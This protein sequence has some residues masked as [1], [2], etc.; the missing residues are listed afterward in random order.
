MFFF[1][2]GGGVKYK[3]GIQN[4]STKTSKMLLEDFTGYGLKK[5]IGF[6]LFHFVLKI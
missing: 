4:L 2:G 1:F 6:G 5:L 3:R